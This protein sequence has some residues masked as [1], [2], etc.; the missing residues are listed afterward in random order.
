[1]QPH[2]AWAVPDF[3]SPP[4][5]EPT[6][7]VVDGAFLSRLAHGSL[8]TFGQPSRWIRGA[9]HDAEGALVVASQ[10]IGG[11]NGHAWVPAD[12]GSVRVSPDA[13]LLPGR[14]LYGGHWIQHF[15]HFVVETLTTLWPDEPDVQ[16]LVFHK[17]LRRPVVQEPWMLRLLELAGRGGLPIEV[18]GKAKPLRVE[19]LVVPS[20]AVVAN[21]WAHPQARQVWERIAAPFRSPTPPT[22][23]VWLSRTE[24]NRHKRRTGRE[25]RTSPERDRELDA[26]FAAVGYE[27]VAPESLH[28]DDQVR[29]AAGAAVLAGTSGSALHLSAFAPAGSAVVEVGDQRNPHAPLGLQRVIDHLC[30]HPHAFL[31]AAATPDDVGRLLAGT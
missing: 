27:V 24:F 13:R 28:V 5:D 10:K 29:L 8:R 18:V 11:T 4:L 9:V 14:W 7:E 20:R 2:E 19:R 6:L 15:G 23:R 26:A 12:P 16:G 1:M 21:G 30:E 17:Y 22:R 3:P 31:P 25:V